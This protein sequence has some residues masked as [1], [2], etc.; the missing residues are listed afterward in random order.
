M[1]NLIIGANWKSNKTKSEARDWVD[2]FYEFTPREGL[3]VIV[4]PPFTLL[5][6]VSS[7]VKVNDLPFRI[8]AQDVSFKGGSRFHPERRQSVTGQIPIDLI[9]EFASYVLVGHS[10]TRK[11][12]SDNLIKGKMEEVLDGQIEGMEVEP[13]LCISKIEELD[14][15]LK[16]DQIIAYEPLEAIGTGH[17]VDPKDVQAVIEEI[18]KSSQSVGKVLYGG[19]INAENVVDYLSTDIDGFLIGSAS[20]DA[21]EFISILKNV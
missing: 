11:I 3:E 10:E 14:N 2:N 20:L 7:L 13:I 12:Y 16:P 1:K 15:M 6:Y 21:G 17:P 8:G 18:K 5:D 4:F 19:S 9:A